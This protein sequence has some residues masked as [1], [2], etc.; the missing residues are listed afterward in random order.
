M[1]T[2][3]LVK[4]DTTLHDSRT[5]APSRQSRAAPCHACAGK[6]RRRRPRKRR[7]RTRR[8]QLRTH[9][10]VLCRFCVL[11]S[12]GQ[13]GPRDWQRVPEPQQPQQA[14]RAI[15]RPTA[16]WPPGQ[17]TPQRPANGPIKEAPVARSQWTMA[18]N[19]H[20]P[21]PKA[22]APV[23]NVD[24]MKETEPRAQQVIGCSP[25]KVR[26]GATK[27]PNTGLAR[28]F[29]S[30][31]HS[32]FLVFFRSPHPQIIILPEACLVRPRTWLE[33][34]KKAKKTQTALPRTTGQ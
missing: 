11:A 3:T 4:P 12:V 34:G 15:S 5:G 8:T 9:S 21:V 25:N 13:P 29:K 30:S 2:T 17:A 1:Q 16:H 10:A 19:P 20:L 31:S 26:R 33:K 6:G 18:C 22:S 14:K 7:R 24:G 27:C 28:S 32:F 23:T